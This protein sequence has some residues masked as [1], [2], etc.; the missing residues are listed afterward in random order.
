MKHIAIDVGT[1]MIKG[2]LINDAGQLISTSERKSPTFFDNG[3][4][5]LSTQQSEQIVYEIINDLVKESDEPISTIGF[6]SLGEAFACI[7]K[8]GNAIQDFILFVSDLGQEECDYLKTK[9]SDEE[10]AHI[11]GVVPNKMFSFSKLMWIKK[12]RPDIYEKIDKFLMVAQYMV[13]RL[14]GAKVCDYTLASRT[15]LFDIRQKVWSKKLIEACGLKESMFPEIK[16]TSDFAGNIS[17]N[18]AKLTNLPENCMVLVSGHDQVMAAV[19]SGLIEGGMANDGIGTAEC[20]SVILDHIPESMDFYKNNFCVVPYVIE[21]LYITYAFISSGAAL[22]KWHRDCLSSYQK[23]EFEKQGINYYQY[24]STRPI[25]LPTSLLVLPHFNGSGTPL[26]D[27][28][29]SGAIIGLSLQT[30]KEEI[31][32]A[33]M[34]GASFEMRYNI[35]LLSKGGIKIDKLSANGGGSKSPSILEIKANIYKKNIRTLTSLEGGIFGCFLLGMANLLNKD[36]KDLVHK[37]IKTKRVYKKDNE[38]SSKYQEKYKHYK[39]LYPEIKRIM[40]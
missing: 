30:T 35:D 39:K 24:Y 1:S 28:S 15:M 14:T 34:E 36:I 18:A 3:V 11:A 9:M 20:I 31:Y 25:Q 16:K 32:Y 2:Q 37:F 13:Y 4:S 38:L 7:D 27:A 33:L 23:E 8:D 19:G 5:F 29:S 10:V 17:K 26:L 12:H 21:G 22:L 6:S 40:R